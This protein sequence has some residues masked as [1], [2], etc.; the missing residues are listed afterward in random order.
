M[1][2]ISLY[3]YLFFIFIYCGQLN[4]INTFKY[5]D[6]EISQE[7]CQNLLDEINFP[8]FPYELKEPFKVFVELQIEDISKIDGKNLDFESFYTL[9]MD[10]KDP[11]VVEVLKKLQV[12]EDTKTPTWL[13]DFPANAILGEERKL[14]N[15]T[16]EIF[17]R[18][19]KTNNQIESINWVDIFSN[20]TIETRSRDNAKFK[21]AEFDFKKFPFDSQ[22]ISFEL[23]S[24]FPSTIVALQ[25]YEPAMSEHKKELYN[26]NKSDGIVIPGWNLIDV[27]YGAYSLSLPFF[28]K[29]WRKISEEGKSDTYPYQGFIV[30]LQVERISNYYLFKIFL[31]ILLILI[32]SWSVFWIHPKQIE[33]KVNITIVALLTLIAY[34]LIMDQEIPKLDYLTFMDAFIFITYLFTAGATILC[35]YSYYR[36]IKYRRKVNLV[37][38]YAKF[39]GPIL[40]VTCIAFCVGIFF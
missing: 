34:N 21:A 30:E 23:W 31:P 6:N 11:R 2:K 38:Y 22:I 36:Y 33:A 39:L 40:Y 25:S 19:S 5:S 8:T 28:S 32:I 35:V 17:N 20:G 37:D 1:K 26:F 13:C 16:I 18:K 12:Y 27:S 9:W 10:W 7:F 14:F 15:P 4:A 3:L 24:E 29:K